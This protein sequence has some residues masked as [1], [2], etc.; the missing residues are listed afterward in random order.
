MLRLLHLEDQLLF[1]VLIFVVLNQYIIF[2]DS[3][4]VENVNY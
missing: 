2:V 1:L 4:F 3:N